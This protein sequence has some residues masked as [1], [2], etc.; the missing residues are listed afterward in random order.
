ML[1]CV[2]V[3]LQ[4]A[5][6]NQAMDDLSEEYDKLCAE[7]DILLDEHDKNS[8]PI[9][10]NAPKNYSSSSRPQLDAQLDAEIQMKFLQIR[11]RVQLESATNFG[12][13]K[14]DNM[15]VV[16]VFNPN[17]SF[18][19]DDDKCQY[20]IYD[21]SLG[22]VGMKHPILVVNTNMVSIGPHKWKLPRKLYDFLHEHQRE[23][24][25][26]I[27]EREVSEWVGSGTAPPTGMAIFHPMGAG[28]TLTLIVCM[29]MLFTDSDQ[30][31][32]IL[33]VLVLAPKSM[34]L[35]WYDE[36]E[37]YDEYMAQN[38]SSRVKLIYGSSHPETRRQLKSYYNA[39]G[40][41]IMTA[42]TFRD[43]EHDTFVKLKNSTHVLVFDEADVLGNHKT[44][45]HER[46]EE[47]KHMP[48][49]V[50]SGTPMK[51]RM[52]ELWAILLLVGAPLPASLRDFNRAYG[53]T[54]RD[55]LQSSDAE[56]QRAGCIAMEAFRQTVSKYIHYVPESF[57]KDKLPPKKEICILF[58]PTVYKKPNSVYFIFEE[59]LKII[60]ETE[61]ERVGICAT[62][63]S[64]I[65]NEYP[66]DKILVFSTYKK[67]LEAV[68]N[69]TNYSAEIFDG[70]TNADVRHEKVEQLRVG[71]CKVLFMTMKTGAHGL[72]IPEANHVILM[73]TPWN[74]SIRNQGISRCWRTGQEK[75]VF[76]YHVISRTLEFEN[77]YMTCVRKSALTTSV[78]DNKHLETH[79]NEIFSESVGLATD[80]MEQYKLNSMP[81]L[82][83]FIDKLP[84]TIRGIKLLD[85]D[86]LHAVKDPDTFTQ[87]EKYDIE[88][89]KNKHQHLSDRHFMVNGKMVKSKVD[90]VYCEGNTT[91]SKP[92]PPYFDKDDDDANCIFFS[93]WKYDAIELQH[94][95]TPEKQTTEILARRLVEMRKEET[96][97]SLS[98]KDKGFIHTS[99]PTR[100]KATNKHMLPTVING[101]MAMFRYRG[102]LN[103]HASAW[104][105]WSAPLSANKI[106]QSVLYQN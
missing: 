76:V 15:D 101:S 106:Q 30:E 99:D 83:H 8:Q 49:W 68:Y 70:T 36:F 51:N 88:N 13:R 26:K 19:D 89:E 23:V 55:G 10:V 104:S 66:L 102:I 4:I 39:G 81:N 9:Y 20:N 37:R 50:L 97:V 105:E 52:A 59:F 69:A 64:S 82:K 21:P 90:D 65:M 6:I 29:S 11:S 35:Q 93:P 2:F 24:V 17:A 54:I 18:D 74:P 32:N 77:I 103:K 95:S 27:F 96:D 22:L 72:H 43:C 41:L 16:D 56:T 86:E 62:L 91:L 75:P 71:K 94:R 48:K 92:H 34:M 14:Y 73:N 87:F 80:I 45:L 63:I 84:E 42:A 98:D 100:M 28:K 33:G 3:C 40:I 79:V 25:C 12:K 85:H 1:T 46:M 5:D 61:D 57:I 60:E 53:N 58:K 47:C 7:E 31:G 38:M 44:K 78:Q 67:Q